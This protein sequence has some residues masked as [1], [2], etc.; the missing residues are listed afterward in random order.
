MSF[1]SHK[2]F[3]NRSGPRVCVL[4]LCAVYTA[5][6]HLARSERLRL[7]SA[8]KLAYRYTFRNQRIPFRET[9]RTKKFLMTCLVIAIVCYCFQKAADLR[10]AFREALFIP[11]LNC[12]GGIDNGDLSLLSSSSCAASGMLAPLM[13]VVENAADFLDSVITEDGMLDLNRVTDALL[14]VAGGGGISSGAGCHLSAPNARVLVQ[15]QDSE[16]EKSTSLS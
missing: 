15:E 2:F 10:R 14:S 6:C 13:R 5:Y 3:A 4:L 12:D 1:P 16:N 7:T 9:E 11:Y 8:D